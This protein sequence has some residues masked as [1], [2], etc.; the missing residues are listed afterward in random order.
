MRQRLIDSV[1]ICFRENNGEVVLEVLDGSPESRNQQH[2][3]SE[4]FE[5]KTCGI[6][7][8]DPE[9]RLFSFNSPFGACPRCQGF[10]NTVDLDMDL[11]IPDKNL[12]LN[13]GAV[14]PWTKPRY[15][16]YLAELRKNARQFGIR[17][18]TPYRSLDENERTFVLNAARQFFDFLETKKYKL[19]VG[20]PQPVS[21]IQRVSGMHGS[22]LR[23][24]ARNIFVDG[25][26]IADVVAMTIEQAAE[27]FSSVH[28]AEA[29]TQSPSVFSGKS[30]RGCDS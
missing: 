2:R 21:R 26:N 23:Q 8:E 11:V 24:E 25:K 10:G 16:A 22:R 30:G 19:H 7:Y 15:R 27:F 29:Q 18:D 13:Q 28:L 1:E 17:M 14:E 6:R 3:F 4:A 12:S 5:C 20:F 9:P